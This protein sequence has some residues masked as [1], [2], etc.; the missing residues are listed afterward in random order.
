MS[1][2]I[3]YE[4]NH[5]IVVKKPVGILSQEDATKDMDML[6]LLK[7]YIKDKYN[8]PGNVYLGLVHRLDRMTGGVMVFARTSKAAS[9][10]NEQ[11]KNGEFSKKY[12]AIVKGII[13]KGGRLENYLIKDEQLV[14]SFVG[15]ERNGK[16]AILDYEVIKTLNDTTLVDVS[17]KTGRHHQIRVQFSHINHPLIGDKLYGENTKCDMCLYAY[18]LS[19]NHPVTKERLSFEAIPNHSIW[20]KYFE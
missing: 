6:T 12:Y 7:H 4:D 13:P 16:L 20:N 9:R 17:L 2:E 18:G 8:K 19:F 14:K 3:L 10:L 5:I 15:N 1:L 11:I